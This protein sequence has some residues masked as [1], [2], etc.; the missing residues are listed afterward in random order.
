MNGIVGRTDLGNLIGRVWGPVLAVGIA[1]VLLVGALP[2]QAAAATCE[3]T[4][5]AD[6]FPLWSGCST[7]VSPGR[8]GPLR[9]G[10]TTVADAKA[11]NYL[12]YNQLCSRWDGVEAY[13]DWSKR[14]R[15][16]VWWRGGTITTKGLRPTASLK[17]ARRL[18]PTLKRTRYIANEYVPG[19]GWT[20]YSVK[21]K[22]GWLDWYRYSTANHS[23]NFF[24]VRALTVRAPKS[25]AQDGC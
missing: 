8:F 18:Y 3:Y 11:M 9:M 1:A 12:A 15:K 13:G 23:N 10:R 4:R 24:A 25:F 16:V 14:Q 5:T 20:V 7:T 6:G 19:Q 21:N 22:R 2:V 17:T